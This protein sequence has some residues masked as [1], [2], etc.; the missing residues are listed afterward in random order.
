MQ[1]EWMDQIRQCQEKEERL[2]NSI[3]DSNAKMVSAL[4]D[5]IRGLQDTMAPH[6]VHHGFGYNTTTNYFNLWNALSSWTKIING[7]K[8]HA[9][10][11]LIKVQFVNSL[12]LKSLYFIYFIKV[13][14]VFPKPF[15][16]VCK[17]YFS[18]LLNTISTVVLTELRYV[19]KD[20]FSAVRDG[21]RVNLLMSQSISG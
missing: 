7:C 15:F 4:M 13:F 8:P 20:S 5:G 10:I 16:Y 9:I 14:T 18:C 11:A 1:T 3:M 21:E 6:R 19:L 2:V 12:C 17:I